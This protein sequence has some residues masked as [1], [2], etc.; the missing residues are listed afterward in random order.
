M[1]LEDEEDANLKKLLAE[2]MLDEPA[3][4]CRVKDGEAPPL[5]ERPSLTFRSY[6]VSAEGMFWR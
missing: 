5:G 2:A 4:G 3:Q 6:E 1:A